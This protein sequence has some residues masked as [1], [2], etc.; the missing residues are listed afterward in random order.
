MGQGNVVTPRRYVVWRPGS[1]SAVVL[2]QGPSKV[3]CSIG[4]SLNKDTFAV[5]QWVK[6]KLYPERC[7]ISSDGKHLLYFALDGKWSSDAKGAW[8][9]LSRAPYLKCIKL[10]PQGHTWGGG[11][12]LADD[13]SVTHATRI[14]RLVRNGW[15]KT[16]QGC[17]RAWGRWTLRKQFDLTYTEAHSL[18]DPNGNEHE[19]YDWQWAEVDEPRERVVYAQ[20]GAIYALASMRHKPKLLFDAN[21]MTFEAL[22]APY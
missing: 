5:G 19:R 16:Q 22:A 11:G 12:M 14:E 13:L 18:A 17:E 1:P 15:T 20:A 4:W 9:G 3:F 8:T 7:D 21:E 10:Y 2:R 6:H